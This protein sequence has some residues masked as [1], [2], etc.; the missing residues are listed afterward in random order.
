ME[1]RRTTAQARKGRHCARIKLLDLQF[2]ND[3]R[4]D[5]RLL[6]SVDIR[7]VIFCGQ[8]AM[9]LHICGE[10]DEPC[11][12]NCVEQ[13]ASINP[14]NQSK[15]KKRDNKVVPS[16][17]CLDRISTTSTISSQKKNWYN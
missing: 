12:N 8:A 14:G 2:S 4:P 6:I 16:S 7:V 17:T 9:N 1:K 13:Y 11:S 5:Q 15:N 3:Q 10:N